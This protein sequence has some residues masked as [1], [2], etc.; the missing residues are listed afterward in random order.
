MQGK[1]DVFNSEKGKRKSEFSP[2]QNLTKKEKKKQK[3]QVNSAKKNDN[4]GKNQILY[5]PP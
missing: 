4:R 5:V 2:D 3:D 1:I